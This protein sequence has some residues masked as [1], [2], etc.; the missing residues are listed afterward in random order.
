MKATPYLSLVLMSG[1]VLAAAGEPSAQADNSAGRYAVSADYIAESWRNTRGGM[2][3]GSAFISSLIVRMA[4]DG[5]AWNLPRLGLHG[6][7]LVNNGGSLSGRLIGDAQSV[8]GMEADRQL[9]LY[10]LWTDWNAG[11]SKHAVRFGIYDL[12]SEFD[13]SDSG[14]LFL[15]SSQGLGAEFAQTG[16]NGPST[17]PATSL[18]LRYRWQP[19]EKWTLLTAAFDAVP[20][21]PQE[22]AHPG[23]HL[24]SREGALLITEASRSG[25]RLR[26]FAVGRWSYTSRFDTTTG[27]VSKRHGNAGQYALGDLL[28]WRSSGSVEREICAFGRYGTADTRINRFAASAQAGLVATGLIAG[29]PADRLGLGVT[30][31]RN[32]NLY[33]NSLIAAGTPTDR[34]ETS[35]ELT[36]RIELATGLAIQP[37]V[38]YVV[39]PDTDPRLTNALA[40][41]VRFELSPSRTF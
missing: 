33:R 17:Y 10:E 22:P 12:G 40:V 18:A 11:A 32:G 27:S 3:R 25:E 36:Y 20:G 9:S 6:A 1:S 16:L 5:S 41:G 24:S 7:L 15:N 29:R 28:L 23:V 34:S 30:S 38:Q 13:Y 19:A 2:E 8:S 35:L 37:D 21:D 31:A 26:R 39:N 14:L 4:A